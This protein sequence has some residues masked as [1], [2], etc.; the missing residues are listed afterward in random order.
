M[1]RDVAV[2]NQQAGRREFTS[3]HVACAL[4]ATP[5]ELGLW[6][7]LDLDARPRR[8]ARGDALEAVGQG[9][10]AV[11]VQAPLLPGGAVRR[12]PADDDHE[13]PGAKRTWLGRLGDGQGGRRV[14][15][16]PLH[17]QHVPHR[18]RPPG[19]A[20][21]QAAPELGLPRTRS[22]RRPS[23]LWFITDEND[24]VERSTWR[25]TTW[26]SDDVV[27][28]SKHDRDVPECCSLL[29]L[30]E[31]DLYRLT[32]ETRRS[33]EQ[34]VRRALEQHDAHRPQ[35]QQQQAGPAWHARRVAA[36]LGCT[37][38]LKRLGLSFNEPGVE[39]AMP[40][41]SARTRRSCRSSSSRRS[42]GICPTAPRTTLGKALINNKARTL[43]FL[44]CDTFVLAAG[45]VDDR[46]AKEASTS[47]AVLLAG[48]LITNTVLTTF[49]IA[50]GATL[51]NTARSALG[52]ALLNNPGSRLAFC[53]D[54]GLAPNV[55]RA[56]STC[57][58]PSSRR[59]SPSGC[60]P[61]ACAATAR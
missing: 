11:P 3:K 10:G 33:G 4:G 18:R 17:E 25:A 58:R 12:V 9:A 5:E 43:G 53:N 24:T 16:Q 35:P 22:P 57:R 34:G 52:E 13:P 2:E 48:A 47:D 6:T 49:N 54:F 14:P 32:L 1:L 39:P 60:S 36:L 8:G 21:R 29:D 23:A 20:P 42:T 31:N 37:V 41:S 46:L 30:S 19:R 44:Q 50:T 45:D 26:A 7:K 56:S 40:T 27:G 15:Q 55:T 38:G 28:L 61:A 59:S 51:E